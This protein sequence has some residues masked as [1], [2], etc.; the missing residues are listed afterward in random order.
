MQSMHGHC[1]QQ[2][3]MYVAVWPQRLYSK[4]LSSSSHVCIT[5][6]LLSNLKCIL[7]FMYLSFY[8]APLPPSPSPPH[9]PKTH[10][11]SL[12]PLHCRSPDWQSFIYIR[13]AAAKALRRVKLILLGHDLYSTV[14]LRIHSKKASGLAVGTQSAKWATVVALGIFPP[15]KNKPWPFYC[16]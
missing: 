15:G 13:S 6:L 9:L 1:T 2:L 11:F 3:I 7:N 10:L 4:C 8:L 5:F 14:R 16:T 12:L